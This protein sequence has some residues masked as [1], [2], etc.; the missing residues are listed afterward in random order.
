MKKYI[1][2]IFILSMIGFFGCSSQRSA[3][4]DLESLKCIETAMHRNVDQP[5]T[6]LSE[7]DIC[8]EKYHSMWE[9][10]RDEDKYHDLIEREYN[11]YS[12]ELKH[13]IQNIVD[14][15]LAIQDQLKD[16]PELRKEYIKRIE[17]IGI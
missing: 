4:Q 10:T 13:T 9:I 5:E 12:T 3:K 6:L 16:K 7:L 17:R 15:D 14:L 1:I 2:S 11:V 8:I